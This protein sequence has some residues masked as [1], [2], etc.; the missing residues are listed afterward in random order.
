MTSKDQKEKNY[1]SEELLKKAHE[2]RGENF[3]ELLKEIEDAIEKSKENDENL[4]RAKKAVTARM[5]SR[6]G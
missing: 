5:A 4:L 1:D 2:Y 3:E 6:K